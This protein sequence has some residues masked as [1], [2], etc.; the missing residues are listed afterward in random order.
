M[1][2]IPVIPSV[3]TADSD[4]AHSHSFMDA[5]PHLGGMLMVLI[6]LACLW[7]LTA[8]VANLIKIYQKLQPGNV[9]TAPAATPVP[10][11]PLPA[12]AEPAHAGISPEIVAV[13]SAAIACLG[14]GK[15]RVISIR[16]A[17]TSWEKAGRQAV[18]MSHRI[19]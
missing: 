7:A 11:S 1:N 6:A 14:G 9:A 18:I 17:D 2:P 10:P 19:R 12:P 3:A 8:I 5:L 4:F 13:I 16:P 15:R